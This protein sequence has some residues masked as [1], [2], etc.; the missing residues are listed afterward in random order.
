MSLA[1]D[2][3]S[4]SHFSSVMIQLK[5]CTEESAPPTIEQEAFGITG[6]AVWDRLELG[7]IAH[8]V[9]GRWMRRGQSYAALSFTGRCRLLFGITRDPAF[10]SDVIC[11]FSITGA[12]LRANGVA[13]AQ[14]SEQLDLWRG[15]MRP[16]S[17]TA[18]T[19]ISAEVVSAFVEDSR[20]EQRLNP[21]DALRPA[22]PSHPA[23]ALSEPS[24]YGPRR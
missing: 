23:R 2:E 4:E 19:M 21:W 22:A 24:G 12:T 3:R 17:W 1:G 6:G 14:Y 7:L 20:I 5:F 18:M 15:L 9:D 8:Y 16:I 11:N 10:I 13:F